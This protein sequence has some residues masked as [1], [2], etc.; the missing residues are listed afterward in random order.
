MILLI[1][2]KKQAVERFINISFVFRELIPSIIQGGNNYGRKR[3]KP[4]RKRDIC[5]K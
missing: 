2:K 5:R 4:R 3:S 1:I